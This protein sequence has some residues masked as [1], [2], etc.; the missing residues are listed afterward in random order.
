MCTADPHP[1]NL[2]ANVK[3]DIKQSSKLLLSQHLVL[4]LSHCLDLA[5]DLELIS[6][7]AG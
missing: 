5:Q 3:N 2:G 4:V 7:R 6:L 1:E